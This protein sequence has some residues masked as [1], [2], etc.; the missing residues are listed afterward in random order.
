VH[1]GRWVPVEQQALAYWRGGG[2]RGCPRPASAPISGCIPATSL[3]R[4]RTRQASVLRVLQLRCPGLVAA[5][6]EVYQPEFA[7]AYAGG[8]R[9][10]DASRRTSA[11]RADDCHA[12]RTEDAQHHLKV[13]WLGGC[14]AGGR[15][16]RRGECQNSVLR[17]KPIANGTL[18]QYAS[19]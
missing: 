13:R 11:K 16:R 3:S 4:R 17:R 7:E 19:P 10:G 9:N 15:S 12:A 14:S 5:Q 18:W 2:P 1:E 8:A 6:R